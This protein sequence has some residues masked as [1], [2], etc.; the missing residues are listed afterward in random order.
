MSVAAAGSSASTRSTVADRQL[1]Q[2][3]GQ[4]DHRQRA[5]LAPAVERRRH[6]T[7][8]PRPASARRSATMPGSSARNRSTSSPVVSAVQR[9]PDVAVASARP[10]PPARGSAA[11][12]TDVHDEPDETAKPRRSSACSSASPSTYR[13]EN[14]TRCG[15]RS[16]GSPTTSTSGTV[17]ATV[18]RIRSTSADSRAASAA[19]LGRHGPQRRR[20][21]HDR[22]QVGGAGRRRSRSSA[23]T[24]TPAGALAHHQQADARA[25]RPTCGRC[26]VSSDQPGGTGTRP[27]DWAAST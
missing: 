7:G 17:A 12:S 14:V 20:G 1:R 22:R 27:T 11:A 15:S 24:A 16:T 26:A 21:G 10:S 18:A 5:A 25:G 23:G 19:R 13:Q 8:P 4:R 9:D 3:P 2:P 6:V